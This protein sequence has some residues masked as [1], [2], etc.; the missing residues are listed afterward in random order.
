MIADWPHNK[1][2]QTDGGFAAAADRQG[3]SH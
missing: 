1:P 2:M 3:V